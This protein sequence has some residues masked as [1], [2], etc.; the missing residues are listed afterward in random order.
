MKFIGL[1]W[2]QYF[3]MAAVSWLSVAGSIVAQKP[4]IENLLH[5]NTA[6]SQISPC[7]Y[8]NQLVYLT[9]PANGRIDPNSGNIFYEMFVASADPIVK[10]KPRHFAN[11]LRSTHHEGPLTFSSDLKQIF[12]TR[13]NTKN[14]VV[15]TNSRGKAGLKLFY[16]YQGTYEWQGIRE[17]DFNS[18]DYSCV[19]PSLAPDGNRIFFASDRPGGFGG[20]DIYLSEW[21]GG[22]WS[23]PINLG[24]EVNTSKD[25]AF[26]FIHSTGRL[27]FSS[28]GL[29]G[30]GGWD[31]FMIDLSGKSWGKVYDLPAPYNSPEDDFGFI[32]D[33]SGI[34]GY[35]SS[36]RPGG[37][38]KDDL[39]T[40][41]A[42]DGL[43]N[44]TGGSSTREVLTVYDAG[45][46][47]RLNGADIWL[48]ETTRPDQIN[49]FPKVTTT[50]EGTLRLENNHQQTSGSDVQEMTTD[51]EGKGD[52]LLKE[53]QS[54]HALVFKSGFAPGEIRFDYGKGG[55]SRALEIALQPSNCVLVTGNV[56]DQNTALG[57]SGVNVSFQPSDCS[58]GKVSAITDQSGDFYVCIPKGCNYQINARYPGYQDKRSAIGTSHARLDRMETNLTMVP[59]KQT[60][61]S[62]CYVM[63]QLSFW[64]NSITKTT[65]SNWCHNLPRS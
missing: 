27:F 51:V 3:L 9:Q 50:P 4:I 43:E 44:F 46:S 2:K 47:R 10:K 42:P 34:R 35:L 8:G 39:Y 14:G 29:A 31:V 38:G 59:L 62:I 36:N 45:T 55:A 37:M 7:L 25:E 57:I 12:Y 64:I 26:P 65:S 21:I 41:T 22:K 33:E 5:L 13:T 54:Y 40:F 23:N 17:L 1:T 60:N 18:N 16:A 11:E 61:G 30:Y 53:G 49:G 52:L 48:S 58:S 19:H 6:E 24:P 63:T 56:A 28:Q 20:L 32:L 15:Q